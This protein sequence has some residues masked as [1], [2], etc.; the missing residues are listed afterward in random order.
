L[1]V[2]NNLEIPQTK[3]N[4]FAIGKLTGCFGIKGFLKLQVH[5]QSLERFKRLERVYVGKSASQAE[6]YAVNSVQFTNKS[7][8]I[9][10]IDVDDR[11]AAESFVGKLIF[12]E[13]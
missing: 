5:T 6:L 2:K 3:Q 7:V 12:V 11:T 10:F 9:K 1:S 4:L 13:E 8:L